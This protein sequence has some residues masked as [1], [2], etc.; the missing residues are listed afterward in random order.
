MVLGGILIPRDGVEGFNQSM[1][2]YRSETKMFA[3]LKWK[4]V[5]SGKLR[6]YVRFVDYFFAQNNTDKVHFHS[7]IIDNTQVDHRQHNKGDKEL[8]FY[9]FYY[10]LL[11]H[12][13]G[14]RYGTPEPT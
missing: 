3:E 12:S 11:L 5:S 13:F 9:K 7:I 4:K 1:A 6:E 8:G 2:K 14:K 10:Q